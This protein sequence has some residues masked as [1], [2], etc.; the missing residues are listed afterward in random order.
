MRLLQLGSA[1][2]L[3]A[4]ITAVQGQ[5]SFNDGKVAVQGKGAGVGGASKQE[6]YVLIVSQLDI[7]HVPSA[8]QVHSFKPSSVLS[9]PLSLGPTDTLKVTLTATDA[10]SPNRPHQAFLTLREPVSG[11]EESFPLAVK[12]TGRAKVEL[13]RNSGQNVLTRF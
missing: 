2:C 11:L 10:D 4:C 5:W 1:A 13:V 3:A 9:T 12:D 7:Q 6:V 8:D